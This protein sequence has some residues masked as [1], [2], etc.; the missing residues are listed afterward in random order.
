MTKEE[1]Y[2]DWYQNE[3]KLGNYSMGSD[4]NLIE[5]EFEILWESG[6]FDDAVKGECAS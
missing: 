6:Y 2:F 5:E 1:T 3:R 4:Q